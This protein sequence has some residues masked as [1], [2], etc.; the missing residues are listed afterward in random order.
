MM[1]NVIIFLSGVAV[2]VLTTALWTTKKLVPEIKAEAARKAQEEAREIPDYSQYLEDE[3]ETEEGD[4]ADKE[5]DIPPAPPADAKKTIQE[6]REVSSVDYSRYADEPVKAE[7]KPEEKP[8]E[9]KQ[10]KPRKQEPETE[11]DDG[12]LYVIDPSEFDIRGGYRTKSY[13][14]YTNG[15]IVDDDT[16]TVVD[17]NPTMVF[18]ETAM[19]ELEKEDVVYVRDE[20]NKREYRV[21]M[22]DFEYD[23][24]DPEDEDYDWGQ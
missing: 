4:E 2:G 3:E 20:A 14:M 11:V 5:D 8:G 7:K 6:N 19:K 21:E 15:I 18:G 10:K 12:G 17:I 23:G 9:K 16:G 24:P 13:S 22:F 1:K